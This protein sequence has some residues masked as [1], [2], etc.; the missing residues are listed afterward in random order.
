MNKQASVNI[1]KRVAAIHDI[2]GFGRC[3]LTVA[4]PIISAA[5]IECCVVPTAVLSTHTGGLGNFTYRDLTDDILPIASHWQSLGLGFDALYSGFLGSFR[6][7]EILSDFFDRFRTSDNIIM[8]DPVMA[9]NGMLYKT[10][11]SSFPHEM[12]K[13]CQKADLI[14]P[15]MTEAALLVDEPYHTGPYS[16]DYV[17]DTLKKLAAL[18]SKLVVLTGVY[19]DDNEL[20]AAAYDSNTGRIDYS[21]APRVPG[22]YPGTGDIFGSVLLAGL[23]CGHDLAQSA[24]KAVNFVSSSISRTHAAGSNTR[25]GVNFEAGLA[26]L[27]ATLKSS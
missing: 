24:E 11:N 19:F 10:F 16:K 27:A 9:D 2:S 18:G 3:S 22:F 14:V 20:G 13:L 26:T 7:V 25:F 21:F 12:R 17:A 5:G 6:Q 4:L 15:N 8:V 1:Q 23:L